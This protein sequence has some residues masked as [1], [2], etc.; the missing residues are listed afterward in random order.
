MKCQ[1]LIADND[2]EG[3]YVRTCKRNAT[4]EIVAKKSSHYP[5]QVYEYLCN[6]HTAKAVK[7]GLAVDVFARKLK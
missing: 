4:H 5:E 2:I 1:Q 3:R 6:I 7:I